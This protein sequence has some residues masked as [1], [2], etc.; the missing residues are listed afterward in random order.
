MTIVAA[1]AYPIS[2]PKDFAEWEAKTTAWVGEA[3]GRGAKVLVFPEYGLTELAALGGRRWGEDHFGAIAAIAEAAPEAAKLF[4]RLAAT[5]GVFILAG[6]TPVQDGNRLV[7]R[8]FLYAPG[9]GATP[10]D[11]LAPTR[12]ERE[13]IDMKGGEGPT[14]FDT[15]AG[16]FGVL[17]CYDSE[18]PL[19]ARAVAEAGATT[20]LIPSCTETEAGYWRV[21][22]GAQ[23][24]ALENQ[25]WVAQ[26]PLIGNA[27]WAEMV[28]TN[29]G[30]AGV[31]GPPD[32]G[33]PPDG[34]AELGGRERPGWVVAN[35]DP[36]P[37]KR[38]R[39]DGGVLNFAHWPEQAAKVRVSE[40]TL[41]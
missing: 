19:H 20:L 2:A 15:P 8:A 24:R 21:R 33:F 39:K 7:N 38:V 17:I 29:R 36:A 31:Y 12:W 1:A 11:K 6:S 13:A 37:V 10:I 41:R 9:G 27:D 26:A 14:V 34:V 18:F 32:L 16:R 40:V 5:H 35:C 28:E 30:A 23:A 3:A 25:F 22:I 4:A